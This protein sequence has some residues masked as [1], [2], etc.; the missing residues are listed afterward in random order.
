MLT[1]HVTFQYI[2]LLTF[3]YPYFGHP[4]DWV[5]SFVHV[6]FVVHME[7]ILLKSEQFDELMAAAAEARELAPPETDQP[8]Q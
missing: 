7:I 4:I 1:M 6:Q 5:P 2:V 8:L 3:G